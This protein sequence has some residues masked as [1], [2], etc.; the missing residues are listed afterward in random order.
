MVQ[1]SHNASYQTQAALSRENTSC[2][3]PRFLRSTRCGIW[4]YGFRSVSDGA[5][6]AQTPR[7]KM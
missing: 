5:Q 3:G 4:L 1:L 7:F 2:C 6:T